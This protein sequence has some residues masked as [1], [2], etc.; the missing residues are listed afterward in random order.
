MQ[1]LRTQT[2]HRFLQKLQQN[3]TAVPTKF[4]T[5]VSDLKATSWTSSLGTWRKTSCTWTCK[6][7]KWHFCWNV[8]EGYM[9]NRRLNVQ[10]PKSHL[11]KYT[12]MQ[13]YNHLIF[14]IC[15]SYEIIEHW[16]SSF[17]TTKGGI[18]WLP[19]EGE[20]AF[21]KASSVSDLKK[22]LS[23]K[24]IDPLVY[25]C[26][27]GKCHVVT[28]MRKMRKRWASESSGFGH[29]CGT[30]TNLSTKAT[31]SEPW[32][33]SNERSVLPRKVVK[34]CWKLP[35]DYGKNFIVRNDWTLELHHLL[36]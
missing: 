13:G 19:N 15:K 22:K 8:P 29:A 9:F 3:T 26:F 5:I 11:V 20:K 21:S 18:L 4:L 2:P 36:N 33:T 31:W 6:E 25:Q 23:V 16:Y 7:K 28:D 1:S 30:S 12:Y 27:C 17:G 32:K 10:I 24:A 34:K 35:K 14:L